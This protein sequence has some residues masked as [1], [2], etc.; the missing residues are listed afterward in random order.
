MQTSPRVPS[1]SRT[2]EPIIVALLLLLA[3][4]PRA[5]L[6][7]LGWPQVESD[8]ATMGLM[9][10]DILHHGAHPIFFYGQ[11]YL[12][13]FQA[14][15]A[16]AVFAMLG[17][18]NLALHIATL[19]EMLLFLLILY[20]L[21]RAV[22]SPAVAAWTLL[23][24]ALGPF[25]GLFL[26]LHAGAGAQETL[27]FGA[28]LL[29]L[30]YLRLRSGLSEQH[31][32]PPRMPFL[33]LDLAIGA[34]AGLALWAHLLTIPFIL[35][36][37]LALA[38]QRVSQAFRPRFMRTDSAPVAIDVRHLLLAGEETR[39]RLTAIS[40]MQRSARPAAPRSSRR[41]AP[42]LIGESMAQA[43]RFLVGFI[44]AAFPFLLANITSR[45][46]T[47]RETFGIA[48]A[49]A[50][51]H[52][53]LLGHAVSL[54]QQIAATLLIGLPHLLNETLI[55]PSCL[56]WPR[57]Q[58]VV[59]AGQIAHEALI[60]LPLSLLVIALWL[61]N[62]VA[63]LPIRWRVALRIPA[64]WAVAW[65]ASDEP[66][67]TPPDGA[68]LADVKWWGRALFVVSA[69]FVFLEY[70][71]S[72]ASYA[73]PA[74]SARYLIG[75]YVCAPLVVAPLVH[76]SQPLW[77]QWRERRF[78]GASA[79]VASAASASS[80]PRRIWSAWLATALLAA[81][82]LVNLAGVAQTLSLA[83][84]RTRYNVP[85]DTRDLQVI[86]YLLAHHATDFYTTYWVCNRLM[87]A[88]AERVT[89]A[90]ISD[91]NAFADG[92]NRIAASQ[93][94]LAATAHPAYVFDTQDAHAAATLPVQMQDAIAAGA[95]RFAGYI[96]ANLAGFHIFYYAGA[97]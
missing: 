65:P 2:R 80:A 66:S 88:A 10:D 5:L 13:A 48:G 43:A 39:A 54:A 91:Q 30:T 74:T 52:A 96:S 38:G 73:T 14:Y 4:A 90:V 35:T 15:L 60:A 82:A 93:A 32:Y 72:R 49:G 26:E 56:Q 78:R 42:H 25:E 21:T 7:A 92:V 61:V 53:G 31:G 76:W 37:V 67:E 70:I 89:C 55:C 47:F 97:T 94:T 33:P 20:L 46:A 22:F 1:T 27:V 59:S 45:G 68:P 75:L 11:H 8:E 44:V 51:P 64:R 19:L 58:A 84:D 3:V 34:V 41:M 95:P 24:L 16:A 57:P 17:P 62:A 23:L 6:A 40:P 36:A 69:A 83:Q 81:V 86:D 63:L 50:A 77:S 71:A 12:G 9:A 87:F 28:A 18:T 85:A 79:A 29:G